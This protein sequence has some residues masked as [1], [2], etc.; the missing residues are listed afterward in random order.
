MT[1][2]EQTSGITLL[3]NWA[4]SRDHWVRLLVAAVLDARRGLSEDVIR[5]FYE[6]LL[7]EKELAAAGGEPVSVPAIQH[8][9][10][11]GDPEKAL[12]LTKLSGVANVNA[13]AAANAG[14]HRQRPQQVADQNRSDQTQERLRYLY[15]RYISASQFLN[16][17]S[18]NIIHTSSRIWHI[19]NH[20]NVSQF[21]IRTPPVN[22]PR[23]LPPNRGWNSTIAKREMSGRRHAGIIR[24]LLEVLD[25]GLG[26]DSADV[27]TR[28]GRVKLSG[29]GHEGGQFAGNRRPWMASHYC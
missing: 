11:S 13:L 16:F 24:G 1:A 25:S 12:R 21:H 27:L 7:R 14:C 2:A 3:V 8:D 17:I 9:G 5:K 23:R 18:G 26:N 15:H 29:E 28:V 4:N 6:H 19:L 22:G 10:K 20:E